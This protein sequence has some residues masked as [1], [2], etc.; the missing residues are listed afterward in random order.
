MVFG[1]EIGSDEHIVSHA[2]GHLGYCGGSGGG[3]DHQVSP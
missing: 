3:N 1:R 2:G